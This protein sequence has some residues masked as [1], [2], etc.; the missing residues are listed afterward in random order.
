M[1]GFEVKGCSEKSRVSVIE[2]VVGSSARFVFLK[3]PAA[4]MTASLN[5][6][7]KSLAASEWLRD[8][9]KTD[10]FYG[11]LIKQQALSL[12]RRGNSI[13]ERQPAALDMFIYVCG[14]SLEYQWSRIWINAV[15]PP[16]HSPEWVARLFLWIL[17]VV[18][19]Y[20]R[21]RCKRGL[22]INK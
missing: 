16:R 6:A 8:G 19:A 18:F 11:L 10:A 21:E 7:I 3:E 9:N 14:N 1:R 12:W 17:C 20:G 2:R 22:E 5:E 4:M 13:R 15:T